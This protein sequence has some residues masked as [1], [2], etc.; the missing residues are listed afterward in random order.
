MLYRVDLDS[1][2]RDISPTICLALSLGKPGHGGPFYGQKT[3]LASNILGDRLKPLAVWPSKHH[4]LP[5]EALFGKC[6]GGSAL[7]ARAMGLFSKYLE[8][9]VVEAECLQHLYE[10]LP[11]FFPLSEQQSI[12]INSIVHMSIVFHSIGKTCEHTAC[13]TLPLV[14]GAT[15]SR[16]VCSSKKMD[17]WP[18][19]PKIC[20]NIN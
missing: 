16:S 2:A 5:F 15:Q 19:H 12:D 14:L 17:V 18:R 3:F 1:I 8:I 9:L 10:W 20:P 6:A 11:C 13:D 7:T 4:K